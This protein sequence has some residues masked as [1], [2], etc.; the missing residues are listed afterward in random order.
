MKLLSIG[1]SFSQDAQRWLH[2]IALAG[3]D[4]LD[5]CNLYI[6]GC[7]LERHWDCVQNDLCDYVKEGNDGVKLYSTTIRDALQSDSYDVITLQQVSSYSGHPQ[8]YIP[9]LTDIAAFVREHQPQAKLYFHKTWSYEPGSNH[10][11]FH[12]YQHDSREMYRRV[13]EAAQMASRLIGAEIIPVG[14]VI[15]SL[16]ENTREFDVQNGGLSLCRDT[17]HLSW[18]Y[19]RFAAG[20]VWYR[21]LTGNQVNLEAFAQ[22]N[23]H[24]DMHLLQV[25]AEQVDIV[26]AK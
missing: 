25:I 13:T 7:S 17:Y 9:Y 26:F 6:G 21:C 15:Q 8:S 5:T 19:G 1:N 24:F 18:D 20:A 12:L 14:D 4:E 3:G 10:P 16:R 23:P 11:N 22:A 2:A